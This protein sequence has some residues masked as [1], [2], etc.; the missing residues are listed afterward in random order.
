MFPFIF[1]KTGGRNTLR[2]SGGPLEAP[3]ALLVGVQGEAPEGP[4]GAPPGPSGAPPGHLRAFPADVLKSVV[5]PPR[6]PQ[7]T[8]TQH[9]E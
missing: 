7:Q 5:E 6:L 9:F 4:F 2:L 3:Q 8:S 1:V